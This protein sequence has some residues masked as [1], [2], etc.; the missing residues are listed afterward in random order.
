MNTSFSKQDIEGMALHEIRIFIEQIKEFKK[1]EA[2]SF[3]G[4][5]KHGHT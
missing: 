3:L 4:E 1:A 5:V 2:E